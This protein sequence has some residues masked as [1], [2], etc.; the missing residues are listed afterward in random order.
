MIRILASMQRDFIVL[1]YGT[2]EQ[3]RTLLK[4]EKLI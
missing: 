4:G 3:T 1:L 2:R